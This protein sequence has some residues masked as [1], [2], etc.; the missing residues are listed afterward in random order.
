MMFHPTPT[1]ET[2]VL[3]SSVP[4]GQVQLTIW[5]IPPSFGLIVMNV[6]YETLQLFY[7][8]LTQASWNRVPQEFSSSEGSPPPNSALPSEAR[9]PYAPRFAFCGYCGGC[10]G[11]S[12][13]GP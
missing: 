6:T 1:T 11:S 10:Q 7:G 12:A 2:L 4:P 9:S 13:E 5:V 3:Y 8:D